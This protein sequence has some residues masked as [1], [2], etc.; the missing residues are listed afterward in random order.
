MKSAEEALEN[1][2]PG[3]RIEIFPFADGGYIA[4]FLNSNGVIIGTG[5]RKNQEEA[6]NVCISEG[7]E[8]ELFQRLSNSSKYLFDKFPS[9]CGMAVGLNSEKTIIRSKLEAFE[10][11]AF[12]NWIDY[13]SKMT[14]VNPKLTSTLTRELE[15]KF[16]NVRRFEHIFSNQFAELPFDVRFG[17]TIGY[18][19]NGVFLGSRVASL[20][21]DVWEH[22]LIESWICLTKIK[23]NNLQPTNLINSRILFFANN[24]EAADKIIEETLNTSNIWRIPEFYNTLQILECPQPFNCYRSLYLNYVPWTE[25]NESRMVY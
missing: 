22:S 18:T 21:D 24:S 23:N 2:F 5:S 6:I 3:F 13:K 8:R 1:F 17:V 15:N 14:E 4:N 11:W 7:I 20:T 12:S 10:R 16:T 19:K 25:G 9:T